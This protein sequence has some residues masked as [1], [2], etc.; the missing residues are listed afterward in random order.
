MKDIE[1]QRENL[2][3]IALKYYSRKDVQACL[4]NQARALEG[5]H[6]VVPRYFE[7]FGKR[8]DTIDYHQDVMNLVLKGATSFHVSEEIWSNP[9]ELTTDLKEEQL[10]KLRVGW[11]L[12][13]DVDCKFL[14]YS[15]IAA[16]LLCEALYFHGIKNL[17]LKFSGGSGFHIGLSY[18]AFPEIVQGIKIKD[19]FPQGPRVIASYLKDMIKDDLRKRILEISTIKEI[20]K[21]V[22]KE[23]EQLIGKDFQFDPFSILEIDTVL[24]ASRHLYRA[25]YSLHE[26]TGLASIVLKPEQIKA[27]HPGW[28]KPE[29][30]IVKKFIPEPEAEEAKELFIQALDWNAKGQKKKE[31]KAKVLEKVDKNNRS[32]IEF[33]NVNEE[34]YPPC[35]KIIL[36]GMKQDGRKR[37]L[38]ILINFLRSLGLSHK[39][40]ENKLKEWNNK[41]Y[42]PLKENYI[43]TQ[44]NWF[45]RQEARLP[46]NCNLDSI[47]SWYKD[48]GVCMPDFLCRKI[49]NPINYV[50]LKSKIMEKMKEEKKEKKRRR[51]S[52]RF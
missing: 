1:R 41:N 48:I 16:W 46:P 29:R 38:F 33:T 11:N 2:R 34:I 25:A 15:K 42:R 9:L 20:A 40:I 28:A 4:V 21:A 18:K 31:E 5:S 39:D 27:F 43:A 37:A 24:I 22:G 3:K 45:K 52:K 50:S 13:L 35:I 30:V 7:G 26:K 6:E 8:P 19:F 10:N 32:L 23:P 17:G 12:I 36:E 51:E 49:K 47:Q 14:E 44:L